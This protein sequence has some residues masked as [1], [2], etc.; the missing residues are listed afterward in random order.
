MKGTGLY[1][2][3]GDFGTQGVPAMSNHL[4][5]A[6]TAR[7]HGWVLMATCGCMEALPVCFFYVT[8]GSTT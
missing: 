4:P 8:Y 2:D 1:N 3:P 6:D 5:H 7:L